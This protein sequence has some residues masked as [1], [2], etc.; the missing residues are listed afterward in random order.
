MSGLSWPKSCGRTASGEEVN[1]ELA[2]S[3]PRR[4]VGRKGGTASSG[5][6]MMSMNFSVIRLKA[7][8]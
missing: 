8:R 3:H 4:E 1:A 7:T 5:P 2:K 6:L